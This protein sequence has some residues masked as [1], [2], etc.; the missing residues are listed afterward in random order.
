MSA[1]PQQP[2][3]STMTPAGQ[4]FL[5]RTFQAFRYKNF[6]LMWA[7]AFTSTTGAFVQ[8][9]AQSWLVYEL[10]NDPFL[11]GLTVFLNNA[12]ILLLSLAGGVAADRMDR[13]KLLIGSQLMQMASAVA[14]ALLIWTDQIA[15]WHIL[16]AAV[17]T[18]TGQAFG[19]PAYQALIPSLV[20]KSNLSNAIALM[21]I[22]FNLAQVIGRAIGG[23]AYAAFGPALC[24]A[25]NGFSFLAVITSLLLLPC[26]FIPSKTRTHVLLSLK[27][28][29][30]FVFGNKSMFSLVLLAVAT[31]FLGVPTMTLLPVFAR[32]IYGLGP[33]GYSQM[34]ALFGGGA[35][36]GA[37]MVAWHG[38]RGRQGLRALLMQIC[39]GAATLAFGLTSNVYGASFLLFINGACVLSV[40]TS[41]NSLV[42]LLAPEEMRGRIMSVYSMAFRGSMSLGPLA[43]GALAAR[44]GAP[45]TV[46]AFGGV[47]VAV[48]V[49]FLMK[50]KHVREL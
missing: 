28:G 21:S 11:L 31:A 42:Q 13:R 24:F 5:R 22:Q 12:P 8:E 48:A 4:G 38:N 46:S 37:L 3:A 32:D 44:H 45:L 29:L 40:F 26:T 34:A 25:I 16:V 1:S 47:L 50:N 19:G 17:F 7:G 49:L 35:V 9:V 39:L 2:D 23:V 6:R 14:L 30:A 10:T 15:I 18:G 27:E 36:V 20:D 41:V 33:A 43:A